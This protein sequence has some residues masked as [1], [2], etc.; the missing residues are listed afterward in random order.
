MKTEVLTEM[1]QMSITDIVEDVIVY[2][3]VEGEYGY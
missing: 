2:D 3:F 1:G